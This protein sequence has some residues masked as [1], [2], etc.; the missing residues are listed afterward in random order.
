MSPSRCASPPR[1]VRSAIPIVLATLAFLVGRADAKIMEGTVQLDARTPWAYLTKFSY[2]RGSGNFT[3]E[4]NSLKVSTSPLGR[5]GGPV[6]PS[7]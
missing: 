2:S 5:R 3:L 1:G 6:R 7:I 4:V